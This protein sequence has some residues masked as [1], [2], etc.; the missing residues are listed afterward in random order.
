M[1]DNYAIVVA[2]PDDEILFASSILEK[3][4]QVFICFSDIPVEEEIHATITKGR[5]NVKNKYPL[6]NVTFLDITQASNKDAKRI[7]W[8][9]A[10]ENE[11]GVLGERNEKE[12]E[13]N[14][15]KLFKIL[16]LKLKNFRTIYTHNPWGEYGH[17]EHI[18]IHRCI[19]KLSK[20]L[21]FKMYVFGYLSRETLKM[22]NEKIKTL[23]ELPLK[24]KNDITLFNKVKDLYIE[25]D[26]WTWSNYH[27]PPVFEFF[28]EFKSENNFLEKS[29]LNK[30]K[31]IYIY[32]PVYSRRIRTHL[33]DTGS[34][35]F[36]I[37]IIQNK[38]LFRM[39]TLILNNFLKP[40]LRK[41]SN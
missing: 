23:E 13:K 30:R 4:T 19:E 11:Y 6:K 15:Q 25:E 14:F 39:R 41:I 34:V 16:G 7:N 27:S 40:L 22:A 24:K 8:D 2:H 20:I 26:C 10:I 32:H 12:Y 29:T 21:E 1:H 37:F 36:K 18:Q 9:R 5:R 31:L 3:A 33:Y 28:Y 35:F 38:Y 17:V